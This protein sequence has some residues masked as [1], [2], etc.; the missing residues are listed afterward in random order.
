MHTLVFSLSLFPSHLIL[1][2]DDVEEDELLV[3][4]LTFGPTIVSES[5]YVVYEVCY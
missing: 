4:V 3:H 5:N 2:S 1:V